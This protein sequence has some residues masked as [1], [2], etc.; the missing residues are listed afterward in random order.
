MS[1]DLDQPLAWEQANQPEQAMLNDLQGNILKSH[2][3]GHA[4]HVCLRFD[5]PPQARQFVRALGHE[6]TCA[7]KQ[8]T[9]SKE[10]SNTHTLAGQF[11]ALLLSAAGYAALEID[12]SKVPSGA[13]FRA[14]MQQRGDKLADASPITW[15]EHFQ[16]ACHAI[17]DQFEFIQR[18]WANNPG[19]VTSSAGLDPII[20]Q[21]ASASYQWP[22]HRDEA[23]APIAAPFGIGSFIT[24]KGGEYFFAPS[25]SFLTALS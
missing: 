15:D 19:F 12:A 3:R 4:A 8:L 22:I 17:E 20:G 6:L 18:H 24:L 25:I 2:G 21:Q 14:G 1:I 11:L 5:D 23:V 7:Q 10:F 13:A 16:H 9:D